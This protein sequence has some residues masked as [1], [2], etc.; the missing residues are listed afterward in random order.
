[1]GELVTLRRLGALL[2]VVGCLAAP[3]AASASAPVSDWVETG[4]VTFGDIDAIARTQGVASDGQSLFFSGNIGLLRTSIDD[5]AEILTNEF[6]TAIPSDL[7]DSGHNHIGDID[8]ADGILYAPIEDGPGYAAPWI[9]LYDAETLQPTGDRY[10]LPVSVLRDGV[11][12]IAVDKPRGVAYTMEWG[13]TGKLFVFRLSDFELIRTV[14][15]SEAVPRIQGAKVFRGNL[16]GSR[17]N[18][19]QKSIVAIDPETGQ[20]T[21]LFD[22]DLGDDYEAEGIAFIRRKTGTVMVGTGI[23]Q[24]SGGY[25]EMRSYRIGGD[26]TAPVLSRVKLAPKRIRPGRALKL[27]LTASERVTV[28]ARWSKCVGPRRRPCGR[29]KALGA[30]R[31]F[32]LEAGSNRVSLAP[33]YARSGKKPVRLRP[34]RWRLSITPTDLAD[35]EGTAAKADLTV[36]KPRRPATRRSRS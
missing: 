29:T 6:M 27:S 18:G 32:S 34:G 14:T 33:S 30:N 13:D 15:L 25:I 31:T 35:I 21:S 36:V 12:W 1:M 9:V 5:P 11:P 16:Y 4:Q 8:V 2:A 23:K 19:A 24:G 7:S 20:V 26:V 28:A 3:A 10:L 17:D 22:R